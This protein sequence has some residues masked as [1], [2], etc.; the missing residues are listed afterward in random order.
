ML[1][2]NAR[3]GDPEAQVLLPRLDSDFADLITAIA[4]GRLSDLRP[5]WKAEATCGVV[6]ASDGYPGSIMKGHPISGLGDLQRGSSPSTAAR[7]SSI[8]RP[9][10]R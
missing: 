2:F 3:L 6:L 5:A 8:R 7:S 10:R 1:E 4:A 9:R